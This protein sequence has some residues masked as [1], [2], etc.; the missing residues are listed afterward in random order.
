MVG[1]NTSVSG[2]NI[3][4]DSNICT[5]Y[6]YLGIHVNYGNATSLSYN[7]IRARSTNGYVHSYCIAIQN[8]TALKIVN[9]KLYLNRLASTTNTYALYIKNI[10]RY[11]PTRY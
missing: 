10:N 8:G 2:N 6:D 4:I 7:N 1:G 3:K 5:N 9:N 11:I